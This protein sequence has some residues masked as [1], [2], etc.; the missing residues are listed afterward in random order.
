MAREELSVQNIDRDGLEASYTALNGDGH[1]F[2]NDGERTVLHVVNGATGF[3]LTIQTPQTVDGLDVADRTVS[4][5]AN[6]EHFIGPF[7]QKNYN[8]SDGLVYVD[9]DNVDDGTIAVLKVPA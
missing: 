4:I 8:Q 5:G 2:K 6:E 9:Y 7:P 1:S 3:D